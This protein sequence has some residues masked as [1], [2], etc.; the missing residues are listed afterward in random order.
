MY[1]PAVFTEFS[2][3]YFDPQSGDNT[4]YELPASELE[5][6]QFYIISEVFLEEG[7]YSNGSFSAEVYSEPNLLPYL[8]N[9]DYCK[10]D[11]DCMIRMNNCEYGGW[12]RYIE[13]KQGV[14]C[15]YGNSERLTP[16][17]V[18]ELDCETEFGTGVGAEYAGVRCVDN[19]CAVQD[20]HFYC[21]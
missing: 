7:V 3:N 12:N 8:S 14:G 4:L 16:E 19:S 6:Y 11:D 1:P 13:F 18:E 9:S 5:Q 21:Q 10:N 15:Q 17:I 2:Q 20:P